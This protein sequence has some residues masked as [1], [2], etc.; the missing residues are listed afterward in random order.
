MR[1]VLEGLQWELRTG[2]TLAAIPEEIDVR[3]LCIRG[4]DLGIPCWTALA[5][6]P[7]MRSVQTLC[8]ESCGLTDAAT[9]LLFNSQPLPKLKS[10]HLCNREGI[11]AGRLNRLTDQTAL[12]LANSTMLPNLHELDLWNTAVGDLGWDAIANSPHLAKLDSAYAW[13]TQLT[14]ACAQKI[15]LESHLRRINTPRRDPPLSMCW[16]HTDYDERTITW[17]EDY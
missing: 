13:G 17:T 7:V 4:T 9:T 11:P 15:K 16:Y 1:I 10:L 12:T 3:F 8:L 14:A 2:E 6:S 5:R